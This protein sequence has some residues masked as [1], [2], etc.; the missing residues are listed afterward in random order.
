MREACPARSRLRT[1]QAK[2][3]ELIDVK[4]GGQGIYLNPNFLM[5]DPYLDT[6]NGNDASPEACFAE[7]KIKLHLA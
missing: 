6:H 4:K 1:A 7:S 3:N 5:Y 2:L